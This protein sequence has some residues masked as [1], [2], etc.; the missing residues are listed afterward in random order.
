MCYSL[1]LIQCS[2][3][4]SP[5]PT[6]RTCIS[7]MVN[8]MPAKSSQ[9]L[10]DM[11]LHSQRKISQQPR[12]SEHGS[13]FWWNPVRALAVPMGGKC[14]SL[15]ALL[16][17]GPTIQNFDIFFLVSSTISWNITLPGDHW[18][19]QLFWLLNNLFRLTSN[20]TSKLCLTGPLWQESTSDW[21]IP[22]TKG[23]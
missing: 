13:T 11:V 3:W 22:L 18:H 19:W 15:I 8:T 7:Y 20:K 23:Q 5:S 17:R 9:G 21:W 2:Y 6:I 14:N 1:T 12:I 10:E 16:F 4:N